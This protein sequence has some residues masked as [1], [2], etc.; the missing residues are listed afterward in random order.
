MRLPANESAVMLNLLDRDHGLVVHSRQ[1][2]NA[3][4]T[5]ERLVQHGLTAQRDFYV[6]SHGEI[7][8]LDAASYRVAVTGRVAE[9]F[10]LSLNMLETR[11]ET[12]TVTATMQCAGNRR[13]DLALVKEV[14]G[15]LWGVGAIGNA[16][17]TGVRLADVLRAA[18]TEESAALHVAFAAHDDVTADGRTFRFGVSVPLAK[19]LSPDVLL[20]WA[21]NGEPLAPEHGYPLRLVVPGFAGIR[22]P[23]WLAAIT[24]QDGPSDNH[25]QAT[26]YRLFPPNVGTDDVGTAAGTTIDA[27][28]VTS[29]ICVPG[30][31]ERVAAG[32]VPVRGYAHAGDRGV[33]RV[34][35]SADG[36][37]SW[38]QAELEH[39]PG[40]PW[41][42]TLWSIAL[43][44]PAG[45]HQL[46]VRAW[47][48]AGQTQPGRPE[49]VWNVKGYLSTAWH[50]VRVTA[51]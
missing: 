1:P 12:V 21:M 27:M 19:A 29:A 2:Y 50:Q 43:V 5:P 44:L 33:A 11:F 32:R 25:M 47:D 49:D 22:S 16:A 9:R 20:A 34:D 39:D 48:V 31:D 41:S 17:W 7:P 30:P 45:E 38:R 35:V 14:T 15:D 3:E 37:G 4:P 6:R 24:V 42:W 10:E 8:R 23:K 13:S 36:G 26:D 51:V 40:A 46:A 18:R 28:P